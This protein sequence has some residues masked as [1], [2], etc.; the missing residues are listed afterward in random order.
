MAHTT[1]M[2]P[3]KSTSEDEDICIDDRRRH[4]DDFSVAFAFHS[5]GNGLCAEKYATRIHREHAVPFLDRQ[6]LETLE[7]QRRENR[8]VIDQLIDGAVGVDGSLRH[9]QRAF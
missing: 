9:V 4:I 5:W 2:S 1:S 3:A 6:L 7:L 8:R